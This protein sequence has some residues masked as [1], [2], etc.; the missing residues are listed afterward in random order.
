[1]TGYKIYRGGS[2]VGNATGATYADM[3]LTASTS[4]S[5]SVAAYDVS[6]NTSAQST[7]IP[8]TT[9]PASG[10]VPV[11]VLIAMNTNTPG[12]LLTPAIMNAGTIGTKQWGTGNAAVNSMTLAA[13]MNSRVV[14]VA[15]NGVS[16][17]TTYPSQAIAYNDTGTVQTFQEGLPSGVRRVTVAGYITLGPTPVTGNSKLFD[18]WLIG[19]AAGNY[20][21]MQLLVGTG[22]SSGY[23][24]NIETHPGST[25]HSAYIPVTPGA[26]YWCVLKADFTAAIAQLAVYSVPSFTQVG[27]V[28]GVAVNDQN[29]SE[30]SVGNNEA[31]VSPGTTSYFENMVIDY[32]NAAFPIGVPGG[33]SDTTP[34]TTPTG[35]TATPVSSSEINLSWTASTDN[36]GV[37]GYDIFRNGVKVGTSQLPSYQDSGL[38]PSTMYSYSVSAY[39]PTGNVSNPSLPIN[40]TTQPI[41]PVNLVQHGAIDCGTATTCA[42]HLANNTAPGDMIVVALRV[43]HALGAVTITD[44]NGNT[45]VQAATKA[46]PNDVHQLYLYYAQNIVGGADTITVKVTATNPT[47]RMTALEYSGAAPSSPLDQTASAVGTGTA[48]SSGNVTTTAPVELIVGI[49][50]NA[51][52]MAWTAGS[53][54]S[55][56][57][58]PSNKVVD[59][60]KIVFSAGANAA[61]FTMASSDIWTAIVAT[62][63]PQ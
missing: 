7:A 36:V 20:A 31:G 44:T 58:A 24:F 14:P 40:A 42:L 25:T 21:V 2:Q 52:G 32:T 34:P 43:G 13:S 41:Q 38:A 10:T 1:M 19:G 63:K 48:V 30:I 15:V 62:F 23:G 5:Y 46:N 26:T 47:V 6:G 49:A 56:H 57:D 29:I 51:N 53:G 17:P 18:Y 3:G 9:K 45:F 39:D 28:T 22:S 35:V 50:T 37:Y 54:F 33:S 12:T 27:Y 60:D 8:A 4:Y 61:T 16:Y 11:D 55:I 59:E